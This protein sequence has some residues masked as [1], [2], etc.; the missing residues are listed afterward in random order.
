MNKIVTLKRIEHKLCSLTWKIPL[1]LQLSVLFSFLNMEIVWAENTY[2]QSTLISLKLQNEA[3]T[4]V[5]EM[6]EQQTDFTFVYDSKMIN[7]DKKVSVNVEGQ[8]IFDILNQLFK[9]TDI[10]YT[11]INK[12]I[13]LNKKMELVKLQE[14][15]ITGTIKDET[16]EPIV[17]ANVIVKGTT[18]GTVTNL[19]GE[20][21]LNVSTGDVLQISY[22]GYILQEIPVGN[23]SI[24]NVTLK[25]DTQKLEEVVV[26]GYGIQKKTTLTGSI[27]TVKTEELINVPGTNMSQLVTGRVAG[28]TTVQGSGEPGRDQA[29]IRI[30]GGKG[31]LIVVDG[32]IGRDFNS[33]NPN[34]IENVTVLKDATATAVYGARAQNG[35]I[36]VTT[37][38]GR[39][40]KIELNYNGYVGLQ[41]PGVTFDFLNLKEK[42]LRNRELNT[43]WGIPD[44]WKQEY[45]DKIGTDPDGLTDKVIKGRNW[46]NVNPY[47]MLVKNLTFQQ[48]HSLSM[49]GGNKRLSYYASL[50][51]LDQDA[52]YKVGDYGFE[53][54]SVRTNMDANFLNETLKVSLDIFGQFEDGKYPSTGNW[55]IYGRLL[56]GYNSRPLK[57]SNGKYTSQSGNDNVWAMLDPD[58]GY[59]KE[60]RKKFNS[61]LQLEYKAPFLKGLVLKVVGAYDYSNYF[62]KKW[63]V[64][65]PLYDF[66]EDEV[67]NIFKKPTLGEKN[68]FNTET[69][70]EAHIQYNRTF[71]EHEVGALFVYSQN[72]SK[73]HWFNANK[74]DYV[75][76]AIDD[77]FMGETSGQSNSGKTF[78]SAR[79]GLVG[80][81]TYGFKNRYLLE[82][83]FRY[84]ASMNFPK[85]DRWGFFP[86]IAV[87]WRVTEEPFFKKLVPSRIM[88]NLKLRASFGITGNDNILDPNDS[89]NKIYFPY[90]ATY[91]ISDNRYIFGDGLVP[92]K[93]T[94][95]SRIPSYAITWE[96]TKSY[97]GGV[98]LGFFDNNL[99]AE[100]DVFYYRTTGI[101]LSRQGK[102]STLLGQTY[103][104]EN[105]GITRRG[106]VD[107]AINYNGKVNEFNYA[108]GTTF[109]YWTSLWEYKDENDG[110]L[111][112]P[113]WRETQRYPTYDRLWGTEG[114][115]QSMDEI[116]DSPRNPT[117]S[118][119]EEGWIKYEDRNGDG[120][121]DE[122]DKYRQGNSRDPQIQV[123]LNLGADYKG[124]GLRLLFVGAA[125][126]DRMLTEYMRAGMH[127]NLGLKEQQDFWTPTNRDAKY[128]RI[129]DYRSGNNNENSA[130][131]LINASY[132][133]LKNIEFSYDF[134]H[135]LIKNKQIGGLRVYFSGNNLVTFTKVPKM[136][137]PEAADE[138]GTSYPLMRVFSFGLNLT[139]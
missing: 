14:K 67:Y 54:Y 75:S 71:G 15:K 3:I 46:G 134:T 131:W 92:V 128:P 84:D 22:I 127:G 114:Y 29:E 69:N 6:V 113:A 90:L 99:T 41:K 66:Y 65:L 110:T 61:K 129:S 52:V 117:Y 28:V 76:S 18:N 23:S 56:G 45:F 93:G 5:L 126:V 59:T 106:G 27:S 53:R 81:L 7:I 111:N 98:D 44:T 21:N 136:I 16:G 36:L 139:F 108:V 120:K 96:E 130:F 26:V 13:I 123:G 8:S 132:L 32:I 37:K 11:V 50:G 74:I 82:G 103:P 100:F 9:N 60:D 137:D 49:T 55:T 109:T 78:E 48:Q 57:F 31:A 83:N 34:D 135:S 73:N 42:S 86:S 63:N 138:S 118:T 102:S 94:Y 105:I 40:E 68:D 33:L 20:Y 25:Q 70:L 85:K 88:S 4:K 112:I 72:T 104:P 64:F 62:E 77:L 79:Q 87:A 39:S 24:L 91:G 116:M 124:F 12:K 10:A 95:E 97:N 121:I 133:R 35:V 107:F 115:Y 19:N 58:H 89:N 43:A 119:I 47:E 1:I 51:C 38:R 101:L 122:Y 30:R 17:G 2:A 125:K 80:R